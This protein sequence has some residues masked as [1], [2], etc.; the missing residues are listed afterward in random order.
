MRPSGWK[1]RSRL[2]AFLPKAALQVGLGVAADEC[3]RLGIGRIWARIQHLAALLRAGLAALPGVAVHDRGAV[4]CGLVSFTVAGQTGEGRSAAV[5]LFVC[6]ADARADSLMPHCFLLLHTKPPLCI[7]SLGD[8]AHW[9]LKMSQCCQ[10]KTPLCLLI[11]PQLPTDSTSLTCI[12]PAGAAA[13]EVQESLEEQH[14]NVSV[15]RIGSTRF[16]FERRGLTEVLR[17]SVHCYNTED[18]LDRFL[19]AVGKL[20]RNV[21]GQS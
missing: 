7:K 8:A 2:P 19:V 20:R 14:I 17:A 10:N 6:S 15:S 13:R 1:M 18:E 5:T 21:Q 12:L 9:S 16:D 4:L 3:V 11:L